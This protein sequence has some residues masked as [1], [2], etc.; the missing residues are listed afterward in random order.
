MNILPFVFSFLLLLAL[1]ASLLFK[2]HQATSSTVNSYMGYLRAERRAQSELISQEYKKLPHKKKQASGSKKPLSEQEKYPD[3]RNKS[4]PPEL[5]KLNL[6]SLFSDTPS[7]ILIETVARL[8]KQLYG[9]TSFFKEAK[10]PRLEYKLVESW[11]QQ[12]KKL[13]KVQDLSQLYPT[14]S[15]YKEVFY[16]MLQGTP[17]ENTGQ[18]YPPL[19]HYFTIHE[20]KE[21]I[22][23]NLASQKLLIALFDSP[24]IA[25][26]ICHQEQ[27]QWQK[28]KK[29]K[30]LDKIEL[31]NLLAKEHF[32][33]FNLT[34]IEGFTNF[35]PKRISYEIKSSQDKKT[36]IVVRKHINK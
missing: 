7:P 20:R 33:T 8:L 23:F 2:E 25:A 9:H 3:Y 18:G 22:S 13:K 5:S 29:W 30:A 4:S 27:L 11:M 12:G 31:T 15:P 19:D 10:E 34:D 24:K 1:G 16:S 32:H 14:A 17:T 36:G 28:E 21:A 35:D 6:T 26:A